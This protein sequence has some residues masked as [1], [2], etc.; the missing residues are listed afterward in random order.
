MEKMISPSGSLKGYKFKVWLKKNKE[1]I[2]MLVSGAV[3][4]GVFF[5]PQLPDVATSAAA[6]SVATGVTKLAADTVDFW[7]S[8]VELPG[9]PPKVPPVPIPQPEFRPVEEVIQSGPYNKH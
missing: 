9:D 3:G 6:A 5:L 2:K 1:T 4:I 8:D 7:I